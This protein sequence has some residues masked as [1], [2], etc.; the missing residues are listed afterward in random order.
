MSLGDKERKV[1]IKDGKN[2]D[3]MEADVD[4]DGYPVNTRYLDNLDD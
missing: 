2:P 3:R 4:A 1:V